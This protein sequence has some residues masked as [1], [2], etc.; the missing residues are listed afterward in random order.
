MST[1]P[2]AFVQAAQVTE[3]RGGLEETAAS[4]LL[5]KSANRL[6]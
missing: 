1:I 6:R 2:S 5:K 4:R 3:M